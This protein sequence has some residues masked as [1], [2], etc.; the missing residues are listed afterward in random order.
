MLRMVRDVFHVSGLVLFDR[1]GQVF[2]IVLNKDDPL[3]S[4]LFNSLH[5]LLSPLHISLHLDQT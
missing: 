5:D 3:A 4:A 1:R 2:G